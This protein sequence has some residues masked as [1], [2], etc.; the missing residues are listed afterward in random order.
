MAAAGE[1]RRFRPPLSG[2]KT[3]RMEEAWPC[4]G[5]TRLYLC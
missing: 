2:V 4:R 5:L 3:R 1:G